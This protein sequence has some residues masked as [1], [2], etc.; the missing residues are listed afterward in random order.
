M[1]ANFVLGW[2]PPTREQTA[3]SMKFP[4]DLPDQ[5]LLFIVQVELLP[6]AHHLPIEG[7][8]LSA[9]GNHVLKRQTGCKQQRDDQAEKELV[10]T[11]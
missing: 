6:P 8:G 4:F 10:A 11:G 3:A 1:F 5:L 9:R 7:L 2:I